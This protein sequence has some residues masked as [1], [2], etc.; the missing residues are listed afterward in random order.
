MLEWCAQPLHRY[1]IQDSNHCVA[2]FDATFQVQNVIY[3]ICASTEC[4]KSGLFTA[5]DRETERDTVREISKHAYIT[6]QSQSCA[7][8]S[9]ASYGTGKWRSCQVLDWSAER[10]NC[11]TK[12]RVPR[13]YHLA[14]DQLDTRH[15]STSN[16][17]RWIC[18]IDIA[19]NTSS[20]SNKHKSQSEAR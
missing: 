16:G 14:T 15:I 11:I 19:I 8:V 13:Y 12:E 17:P 9:I 1:T 5:R 10:R 7:S 2:I 4:K 3:H 20:S 18:Q 6:I